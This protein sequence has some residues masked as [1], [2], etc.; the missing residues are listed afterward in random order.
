M[1]VMMI[2]ALGLGLAA[3]GAEPQ[4]LGLK[5]GITEAEATVWFQEHCDEVSRHVADPVTFPFAE[6]SEVHI[7]C[8]LG[9]QDVYA[10]FG[11]DKL[12]QIEM[13]GDI[14]PY[15]PSGEAAAELGWLSVYR[16]PLR[17]YD[18]QENRLLWLEDSWQ[19]TQLPF[20]VNP[21]WAEGE[22]Q[23]DTAWFIPPEIEWGASLD[24][25]EAAFGDKCTHSYRLTFDEVWLITQPDLLQQIDCFGYDIAGY[26]R[27]LE[28]IF[29]DG[30]LEQI[31][32]LLGHGDVARAITAFEAQ[33][34]APVFENEQYTVF[35]HLDVAVRKDKPELLLGSP[36]VRE[37]WR[38]EYM[39]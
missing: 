13:R 36:R 17:I 2:T 38:A 6:D 22:T 32:V 26:P 14:A 12:I 35:G 34:G 8:A 21:I 10:S 5:T 16:E 19:V 28:L 1:N 7:H 20:W 18:A 15:Q 31:W 33:Y 29:G 23:I 3:M 27:K 25:V 39:Q 30:Q 4:S 11:D 24:A 9:A 37:L